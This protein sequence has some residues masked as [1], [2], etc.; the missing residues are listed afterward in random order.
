M[1]M[2]LVLPKSLVIRSIPQV[3]QVS[4]QEWRRCS[5]WSRECW[6]EGTADRNKKSQAKLEKNRFKR[7]EPFGTIG[8]LVKLS[9]RRKYTSVACQ[10]YIHLPS[11]WFEALVARKISSAASDAFPIVCR[12]GTAICERHEDDA[13]VSRERGH[14]AYLSARS[15]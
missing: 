10:I 6:F 8:V 4:P 15:Q 3:V 14:H 5:I 2:T 11:S 9:P 1:A 12:Y 13:M 7:H